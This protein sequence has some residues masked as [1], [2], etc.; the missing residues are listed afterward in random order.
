MGDQENIGSGVAFVVMSFALLIISLWILQRRERQPIKARRPWILV[1]PSLIFSAR[2]IVS[3]TKYLAPATTLCGSYYVFLHTLSWSTILSILVR[4]GFLY[5][6]FVLGK[7][8][9]SNEQTRSKLQ[10][11]KHNSIRG[12]SIPS[13]NAP[14]SPQNLAMD[15][16]ALHVERVRLLRMKTKL[17]DKYLARIIFIGTFTFFLVETVFYLTRPQVAIALR[18]STPCVS[19]SKYPIGFLAVANMAQVIAS[20]VFLKKL[21]KINDIFKISIEF[22]LIVIL[23]FPTTFGM[24]WGLTTSSLTVHFITDWMISGSVFCYLFV[25]SC[26]VC[27]LSFEARF[28]SPEALLNNGNSSSNPTSDATKNSAVASKLAEFRALLENIAGLELFQQHLLKELSVENIMFWNAVNE[29]KYSSSTCTDTE[30]VKQ[31]AQALFE[32]YV[33]DKATFQVNISSEQYDHI[34]QVLQASASDI[35]QLRAVFDQAQKEIFLLMARDSFH[36]FRHTEVY[37]QWKK[38]AQIDASGNLTSL[39]LV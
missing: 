16:V 3:S 7:K 25:S 36:R 21:M 22:R 6:A 26:Y 10:L 9:L 8:S 28:Q 24:L 39:Q 13:S 14:T 2:F 31:S 37:D 1:T 17:S 32:I 20:L 33:S 12:P 23:V 11:Q 18:N 38:K 30:E 29:F 27:A 4:M 15:E 34:S 35:Q 5:Y 19:S